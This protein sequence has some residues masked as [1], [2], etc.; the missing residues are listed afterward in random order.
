M[1]VETKKPR[2]RATREGLPPA[3]KQAFTERQTALE[4]LRQC[5]ERNTALLEAYQGQI[6]IQN[7]LMGALS[8]AREMARRFRRALLSS[9]VPLAIGGEC[10]WLTEE[11][12]DLLEP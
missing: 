11:G 10:P 2:K 5:R 8:E 7:N 4:E 12:D 9:G 6:N 3:L 1:A